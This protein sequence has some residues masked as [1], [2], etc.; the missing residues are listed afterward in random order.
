MEAEPAK[1]EA[2]SAQEGKCASCRKSMER[3]WYRAEPRRGNKKIPRRKQENLLT[4][5]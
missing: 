3:A 2:G 5:S 4:E 1:V